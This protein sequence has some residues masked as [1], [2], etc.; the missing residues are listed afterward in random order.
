MI[1]FLH[2][3]Q[4]RAVPFAVMHADRGTAADTVATARTLSAV[5]AESRLETRHEAGRV[6]REV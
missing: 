3:K 1:V 5:G 2:F 4:R 6:T